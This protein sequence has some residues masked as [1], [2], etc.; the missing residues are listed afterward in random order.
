MYFLILSIFLFKN[1]NCGIVNI[2][3]KGC[4]S[5][6]CK[7]TCNNDKYYLDSD[8]I[9]INKTFRK[10]DI[11]FI[12]EDNKYNKI[13]QDKICDYIIHL[14]QE[15]KKLCIS[16]NDYECQITYINE[17]KKIQHNNI[18]YKTDHKK[19]KRYTRDIHFSSKYISI[20]DIK[21]S[22][23]HLIVH[24]ASILDMILKFNNPM[25]K[26]EHIKIFSI[27]VFKNLLINV[28]SSEF[29]KLVG[30]D[31]KY[32]HR[33]LADLYYLLPFITRVKQ[34]NLFKLEVGDKHQIMTFITSLQNI[35]D[36]Y[37]SDLKTSVLCNQY[38]YTKNNCP[39]DKIL[40]DCSGID[41]DTYLEI[42]Y[43]M[44]LYSNEFN[45]N[46]KN[47]IK[48]SLGKN[49][50]KFEQMYFLF[51]KNNN[52]YFCNN[53]KNF[54]DIFLFCEEVTRSNLNKKVSGLIYYKGVID[55]KVVY[56]ERYIDELNKIITNNITKNILQ[57]D[58]NL[59]SN[60]LSVLSSIY[61]DLVLFNNIHNKIEITKTLDN[62]INIL[63]ILKLNDDEMLIFLRNFKIFAYRKDFGKY[64]MYIQKIISINNYYNEKVKTYLKLKCTEYINKIYSVVDC[65][66]I[67]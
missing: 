57:C 63:N 20:N 22:N 16:W 65:T 36:L 53:E 7:L 18:I 35:F 5:D 31:R 11:Y 66:E 3:D 47:R 34:M 61:T 33:I 52:N 62:I 56:A 51:N 42:I 45:V 2:N 21:N 41:R 49:N 13:E 58:Q 25:L 12:D 60:L 15:Y 55:M 28:I 39:F 14:S 29:E 27:S 23:A 59:K 9:F 8:N 43:S 24:A 64:K 48:N 19:S 4:I 10:G 30:L 50:E 37:D 6:Y 38:I 1:I 17:E 67:K 54:R 32:D 40:K 46:C 26:L 44:S